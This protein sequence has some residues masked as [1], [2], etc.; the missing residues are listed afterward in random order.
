MFEPLLFHLFLLY[1][2]LSLV[3]GL[4]KYARSL[5]LGKI[6][7]VSFLLFVET[8]SHVYVYIK[9]PNTESSTNSLLPVHMVVRTVSFDLD[10]LV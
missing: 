5:A 9:I 4:L 6:L 7:F 8:F 2:S 3:D 10:H 1:S